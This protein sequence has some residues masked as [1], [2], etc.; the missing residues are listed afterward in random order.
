[1]GGTRRPL[2]Q[3]PGGEVRAV[4]ASPGCSDYMGEL[5]ACDCDG[6]P[7]DLCWPRRKVNKEWLRDREQWSDRGGRSLWG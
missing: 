4:A 6:G 2:V 3:G 5:K 1:M 7:W